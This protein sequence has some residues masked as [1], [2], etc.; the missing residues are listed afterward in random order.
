LTKYILV[1]VVNV[2]CKETIRASPL[3]AAL[4]NQGSFPILCKA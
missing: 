4:L 1:R 2:A 3:T